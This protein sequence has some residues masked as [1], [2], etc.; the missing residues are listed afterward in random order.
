MS[1]ASSETVESPT[2]AASPASIGQ[3]PPSAAPAPARSS[4]AFALA[5]VAAL[6]GT[7]GL[8]ATASLPYW[9]PDLRRQASAAQALDGRI[10]T[11]ESRL[12][13]V[14]AAGAP[15]ADRVTALEA[16]LGALDRKIAALP[17]AKA[18]GALAIAQLTTALA[19]SDPFAA[20]LVAVRAS[21][22][23]DATLQAALDG[24][25]PRAAT[26]IPTAGDLT[27]RF[28]LV[29]PQALAADL[30]AA[31]EEAAKAAQ[32]AQA[33]QV[34]PAPAAEVAT[35]PAAAPAEGSAE[36]AAAPATDGPGL[37]E[38]VWSLLS[39]TADLLRTASFS[40][41]EVRN[42]ASLLEQAGSLIASGDLVAT[43]EVLG[44][45]EGAAAE[46]AG[47]WL[48]DARA[49]VAADQAAA[50]LG[51]RAAALLPAKS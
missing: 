42:A 20:Q 45:L 27:E 24:L 22:V 8:A 7:A 6:L 43:V 26:G 34:A 21:G 12:G 16:S 30:R 14:A 29:V 17:D 10:G 50:L 38:Q 37:Y 2:P 11:V 18:F 47:P 25:A 1:S 36:T 19:D 9:S 31:A 33:A 13:V 35:P 3:T 48:E 46:T 23:A 51:A 5:V 44:K 32:A 49:R 40:G 15:L 41:G 4:G 28:L 39:G